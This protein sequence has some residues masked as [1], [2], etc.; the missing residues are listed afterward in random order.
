MKPKFTSRELL[1]TGLPFVLLAGAAWWFFRA[2][3]GSGPPRL[4]PLQ[5]E[6]VAL[7]PLD[8]AHGF[9]FVAKSRVHLESEAP[10]DGTLGLVC[11]VDS[12]SF[13]LRYRREEKWQ[14][15]SLGRQ[16]PVELATEGDNTRL[17]VRLRAVPR[18]VR[19]VRASGFFVATSTFQAPVSW[20]A[21]SP[22]FQ[23]GV[24]IG[25]RFRIWS[26]TAK[27]PF[28]IPIK[29]PDEPFPVP[30]VSRA[31]NLKLI[32]ARWFVSAR[33]RNQIWVRLRLWP[34]PEPGESL[35]LDKCEW[36][37]A[38][39]HKILF[40]EAGG[41]GGKSSLDI[42][43]LQPRL[44]LG[45]RLPKDEGVFSPLLPGVAPRG[46]WNLLK[47][48]LSLRLRVS[49]NR[50]WPLDINAKLRPEQANTSIYGA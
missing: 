4:A 24:S 28:D 30:V 27:Q 17:R 3:S 48:P 19:E 9:D 47:L 49:R 25:K 23:P 42:A 40:Y 34:V 37:D 14:A 29:Q 35:L 8:V 31:T 7:S 26:V 2:N 20:K 18:D 50:A 44:L 39:G 38:D 21:P 16:L 32:E 43:R 11:S 41:A 33:G 36:F 22:S 45:S 5:W 12:A 1:T 15:A 46:G 10:A 13:R 6:R